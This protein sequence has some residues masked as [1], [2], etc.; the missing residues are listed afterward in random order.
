MLAAEH[1]DLA[2]LPVGLINGNTYR[3]GS[4]PPFRP[5]AVIAAIR[6]VIQHPDVTDQDVVDIVGAPDFITGCTVTGNLAAFAAG[7]PTELRLQATIT[8]ADD[9][10]TVTVE[11]IPPNVT[12]DDAVAS[13]AKRAKVTSDQPS[14]LHTATRLDLESVTDESDRRTPDGRIVCT[15]AAGVSAEEVRDQLTRVYGVY[16]TM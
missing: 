13:I 7:Q 15:P 1:R 2:P 16:T 5:L 10:R 3:D 8:I 14:E 4:Q 6:H 9:R 12:T 11:N